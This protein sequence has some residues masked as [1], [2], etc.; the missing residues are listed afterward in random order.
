MMQD[1]RGSFIRSTKDFD[2]LKEAE[3]FLHSELKRVGGDPGVEIPVK[4]N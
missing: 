1:S 2:T 3:D 4:R